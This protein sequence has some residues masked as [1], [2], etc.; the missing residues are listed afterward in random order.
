MCFFNDLIIDNLEMIPY[1]IE[2][3][4]IFSYE[5]KTLKI[6]CLG[7]MLDLLNF[8]FFFLMSLTVSHSCSVQINIFN[9]GSQILNLIFTYYPGKKKRNKLAELIE[10]FCFFFLFLNLMKKRDSREKLTFVFFPF[11]LTSSQINDMQRFFL[12]TNGRFNLTKNF[13]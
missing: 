2:I 6:F 4:C 12:I 13:I 7:F 9:P 10:N 1:F 3:L 8:L 11:R 5:Q